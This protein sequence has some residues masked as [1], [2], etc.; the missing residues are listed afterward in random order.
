MKKN[1]LE[2]YKYKTNHKKHCLLFS[3]TLMD[4][5]LHSVSL[6]F[7]INK[8]YKPKVIEIRQ[9]STF[10]NFISNNFS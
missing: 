8:E 7:K 9:T 10:H 1:S 2:N 4:S 3:E 6:L 5:P